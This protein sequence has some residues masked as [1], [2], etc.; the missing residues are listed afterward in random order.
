MTNVRRDPRAAASLLASHGQGKR[1]EGELAAFDKA[2]HPEGLPRALHAR[3][4][5]ARA[6]LLRE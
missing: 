4:E 6:A 5:A 3:R 1:A 2:W